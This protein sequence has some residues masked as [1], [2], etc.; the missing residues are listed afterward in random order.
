MQRK[1]LIATTNNGKLAEMSA[2]LSDFRN[3]IQTP[4][5][6]NLT[7]SVV[8]SGATYQENALLKA[9]AYCEASGLP[10]LADDTGLEVDALGGAPGLYSARFSPKPGATD[11]DRRALLLTKLKAF[12]RPWKAQFTCTTAFVLPDG[13]SFTHIGI[14]KG[15]II[16]QERGDHGFG[17]DRIFLCKEPNQTMAELNMNDKNRISHRAKAIDGLREII[18]SVL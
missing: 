14:C 15:E 5:D 17:Y 9:R 12:P 1:F 8:E 18:R 10:T 2:L 4:L 6:L 13:K 16:S 11:A 7:L 3:H